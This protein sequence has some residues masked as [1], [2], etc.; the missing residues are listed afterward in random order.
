MPKP[1]QGEHPEVVSSE[2]V[3]TSSDLDGN[4]SD[5]TVL[6]RALDH[7]CLYEGSKADAIQRKT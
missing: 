6:V 4:A 1:F 3:G 7:L 5:N 2:E